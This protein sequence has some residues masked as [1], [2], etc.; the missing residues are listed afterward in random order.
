MEEGPLLQGVGDAVDETLGELEPDAEAE[1]EDDA[2][3]EAAAMALAAGL[4]TD[5]EGDADD[6]PSAWAAVAVSSAAGTI[7]AVAAAADNVR[8]SFMCMGPRGVE[9]EKRW[10]HLCDTSDPGSVVGGP[11]CC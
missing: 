10:I 1:A 5:A 9:E 3:S 6:P 2:E 8:R 4:D 7:A 11:E